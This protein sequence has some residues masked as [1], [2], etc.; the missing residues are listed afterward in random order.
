M[1]DQRDLSHLRSRMGRLLSRLTARSGSRMGT[2]L[3]IDDDEYMRDLLRLHLS[4]AGYEEL[5]AED[6]VVGGHSLFRQRPDLI[7]LDRE[8]P[9]MTGLVCVIA[10]EAHPEVSDSPGGFGSPRHAR[11][12]KAK[13]LG[14]GGFRRKP[15]LADRLLATVAAYVER[16]R[17]AL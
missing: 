1:W 11:A 3:V 7:L 9:S 4:N 13:E 10:L 17:I 2:I 15:S 14:A 8:L 12:E 6:A 5:V 16:G